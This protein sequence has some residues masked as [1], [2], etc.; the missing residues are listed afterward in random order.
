MSLIYSHFEVRSHHLKGDVLDNLSKIIYFKKLYYLFW[1][2]CK[3]KRKRPFRKKILR[4]P[5]SPP[6]SKFITPMISFTN[7]ILAQALSEKFESA[8]WSKVIME[9]LSTTKVTRTL[10]MIPLKSSTQFQ[11][12]RVILP[13]RLQI[14]HQRSLMWKHFSRLTNQ[15][16]R[17]VT[18]W[19]CSQ[20]I[21]W[22]RTHKKAISIMRLSW[23]LK[24][25]THWFLR[26]RESPRTKEL[27]TSTLNT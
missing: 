15:L 24:W 14:P 17:L 7:M 2:K 13:T 20:S 11:W 5:S 9:E 22:S 10:R 18:L 6:P 8:C 19:I 16:R 1:Q 25:T 3:K 27:S 23:C 26:C 21:N 4:W 12:M